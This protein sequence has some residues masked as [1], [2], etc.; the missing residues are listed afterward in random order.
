[1]KMKAR[2]D[3]LK[4]AQAGIESEQESNSNEDSRGRGGSEADESDGES[5]KMAGISICRLKLSN[6][7]L[8]HVVNGFTGDPVE[9]RPFDFCF[10]QGKNIKRWIVITL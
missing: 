10:T 9:L 2:L 8:G 3:V 6:L 7:D 5:G 4:N 1:M